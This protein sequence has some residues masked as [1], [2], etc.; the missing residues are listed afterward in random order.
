MLF[1]TVVA[2]LLPFLYFVGNLSMYIV[3]TNNIII[4][5]IV[6]TISGNILL[7]T[8]NEIQKERKKLTFR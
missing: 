4:M 5:L 7:L 1:F 8:I 6:Y 3:C 2:R